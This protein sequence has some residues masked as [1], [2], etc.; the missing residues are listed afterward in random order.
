M[1]LLYRYKTTLLHGLLTGFEDWYMYVY[2]YWWDKRPCCVT[3]WFHIF[4]YK[5]LG[6]DTLNFYY[7]YLIFYLEVTCSICVFRLWYRGKTTPFSKTSLI[8]FFYLKV[9]NYV[10][11]TLFIMC[12]L[13][14][15]KWTLHEAL[16]ELFVL[17]PFFR[18]LFSWQYITLSQFSTDLFC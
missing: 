18:G 12:L 14:L 11:K 13:L 10:L 5:L 2:M 3:I 9:N 8:L 4:E 15:S 6:H 7:A 17:F 1:R 16:W